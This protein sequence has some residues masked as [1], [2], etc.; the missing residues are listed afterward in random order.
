MLACLNLAEEMLFPN[1]LEGD[2]RLG[3]GFVADGA[4][5]DQDRGVAFKAADGQCP[6][7]F[8][9]N[10]TDSVSA[11]RKCLSSHHKLVRDVDNELICG[12]ALDGNGQRRQPKKR[13]Q[14][15]DAML[16]HHFSFVT[17]G[18]LLITAAFRVVAFTAAPE[19][20]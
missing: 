13:A 14:N 16:L 20:V 10:A 9:A 18:M 3:V 7:V 11:R 5:E 8:I 19:I 2:A 17:F 4:W 12:L 6:F 15:S 1:L